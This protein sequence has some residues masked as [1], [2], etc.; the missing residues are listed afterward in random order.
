[1]ANDG[2][3]RVDGDGETTAPRNTEKI[4]LRD[5][6]RIQERTPFQLKPVHLKIAAA[7]VVLLTALALAAGWLIGRG[8]RGAAPDHRAALPAAVSAIPV[9]ASD[10]GI[11]ADPAITP[12]AGGRNVRGSILPLP[13]PEPRPGIEPVAKRR[14]AVEI[15]DQPPPPPPPPPEFVDWTF[16]PGLLVTTCGL[17]CIAEDGDC[18][19]E[20]RPMPEPPPPPAPVE[21][22]PVPEVAEP[23]PDVSGPPRDVVEPA[24]EAVS[25]IPPVEMATP[26][27]AP[28]TKPAAAAQK[29]PRP[30]VKAAK[31]PEVAPRKFAVQIRSFKDEPAAREFTDQIRGKGYNPF[32]VTFTDANGTTWYRVRTGSFGTAADAA[33]FAA[34]LNA[35]EA[36]QSIPVEVK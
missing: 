29:A 12:E 27:P 36:E 8:D 20:D 4:V 2:Q 26:A 22:G 24:P 35:K 21:P 14:P 11:E 32:I 19:P 5:Y 6:D 28:V 17:S 3:E 13:S 15:I 7:G 9:P 23:A 25:A 31:P 18:R 10:A 16:W 34:E 33:A 30:V 1:M